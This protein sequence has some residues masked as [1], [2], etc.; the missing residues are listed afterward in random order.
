MGRSK[1]PREEN[2]EFQVNAKIDAFLFSQLRRMATEDKR[3][4]SFLTRE[5]IR[6]FVE[7]HT[8]QGTVAA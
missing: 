4:L 1:K 8:K 7:R 6:E 3:S 5:A 2:K